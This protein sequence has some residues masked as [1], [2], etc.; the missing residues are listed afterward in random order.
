PANGGATAAG[1]RQF[2]ADGRRYGQGEAANAYVHGLALNVAQAV[3][4]DLTVAIRVVVGA[5]ELREAV[6]AS[7]AVLGRKVA[8]APVH[9][10]EVREE[11]ALLVDPLPGPRVG[12]GAERIVGVVA[13]VVE[14]RDDLQPRPGV[15]VLIDVRHRQLRVR[16]AVGERGVEHA[17]VAGAALAGEVARSEERRVG[18]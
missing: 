2:V 1:R 15:G 5:H 7:E 11:R 16:R 9:P 17:V 4:V 18:K 14:V 13:R 8:G 12:A 6:G 10:G 3:R